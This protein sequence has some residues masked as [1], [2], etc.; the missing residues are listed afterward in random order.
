MQMEVDGGGGIAFEL[1]N[2]AITP[3]AIVTLSA[4]IAGSI[5]SSPIARDGALAMGDSLH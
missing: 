4:F 5:G 3:L 2:I 1:G